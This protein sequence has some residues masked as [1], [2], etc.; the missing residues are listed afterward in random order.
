MACCDDRRHKVLVIGASGA[1]GQQLCLALSQK[2]GR[3]NVVAAVRKTPLPHDIASIVTSEKGV[4]VRDQRSLEKVL[5]LHRDNIGCIWN[6]AAPLSVETAKDPSHAECVTV[7]GMKNLINA[8][9]STGLQNDVTLCFTDSIGSFGSSAPRDSA[10]ARW[11][12]EHP[13]QDPGS[14]YGRQKRSC[15]EL[16]QGATMRHGLDTRWAVIP[17]VLHTSPTWGAGTT[18]YALDAIAHAVKQCTNQPDTA[19]P[20]AYE[21]PVPPKAVLPMIHIADLVDG[22]LALACA[23]RTSIME[24][25]GGYTL[26][27]FSFDGITLFKALAKLYPQFTWTSKLEPNAALFAE[28]WP[29]SLSGAEAS[30]DFQFQAQHD[31]DSTVNAIIAAHTQRIQLEGTSRDSK[32]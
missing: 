15:R 29:D 22:L 17:G 23:P 16:M 24:P 18:E 11:L 2:Y 28:T 30:R 6:L 31:F 12:V 13:L 27:G 9:V 14:D 19:Q 21:C 8:I 4:D 7:G 26:A 20:L 1:I 10:S 5:S 3:E 25:D 32:L